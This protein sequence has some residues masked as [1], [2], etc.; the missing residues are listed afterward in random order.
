MVLSL[1]I[2]R[3]RMG[4]QCKLSRN[5]DVMWS[6]FRFRMMRRAPAFNTDCRACRLVGWGGKCLLPIPFP[7]T[8]T[9]SW[10]PAYPVSLRKFV[11]PPMVQ[12]LDETLVTEKL[13]YS[14]TRVKHHLNGFILVAFVKVIVPFKHYRHINRSNNMIDTNRPSS[15]VS[16]HIT[17]DLYRTLRTADDCG[18][19]AVWMFTRVVDLITVAYSCDKSHYLLN[20]ITCST[21]VVAEKLVLQNE[22]GFGNPSCSVMTKCCV[23]TSNAVRQNDVGTTSKGK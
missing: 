21:V 13:C 15:S 6:Y 3:W 11:S 17:V 12:G 4:S 23:V 20:G 8:P 14:S 7:S 16:R 2:I 9:V 5:D 10:P 19:D 18:V 1:Y 22:S